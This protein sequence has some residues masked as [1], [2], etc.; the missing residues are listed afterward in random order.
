MVPSKI[1]KQNVL[2]QVLK[3]G[4]TPD[5]I[6]AYYYFGEDSIKL[7]ET[8]H[9]IRTKLSAIFRL[10]CEGH[11]RE[12]AKHLVI[13][14]FGGSES[15]YYRDYLSAQKVYGGLLDTTD[16]KLEKSI[17]SEMAMKG[18]RLAL[19][20]KDVEGIAK[21]IG[22]LIKINGFDRE[23]KEEISEDELQ[24]HN[25][26]MVVKIGK[27]PLKIDFNEL[28]SLHPTS[29]KKLADMLGAEITDI[30]AEEIMNK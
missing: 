21:M 23:Q 18:Y 1:E 20:N 17:I 6:W 29:R 25:Y 19:K 22:Q 2:A 5:R 8:E 15:Q 30:E 3:E 13:A 16:F 11:T 26:Y 7:S 27:N 12:S 14:E 24:S 4:T 10:R 9:R 28:D